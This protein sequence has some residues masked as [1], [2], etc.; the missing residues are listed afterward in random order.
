MHCCVSANRCMRLLP[1]D[2]FSVFGYDPALDI[3]LHGMDVMGK[4]K[5]KNRASKF[6]AAAVVDEA[7]AAFLASSAGAETQE[8][9][10]RRRSESG[11]FEPAPSPAASPLPIRRIRGQQADNPNMDSF[12]TGSTH[13]RSTVAD[14]AKALAPTNARVGGMNMFGEFRAE[15]EGLAAA[16]KERALKED[17]PD[18]ALNSHK[19]S[20]RANSGCANELLMYPLQ[21]RFS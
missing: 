1:T 5:K 6:N 10:G 20:S 3:Q 14:D 15:Q 12:V 11:A 7:V 21:F 9:L 19:A 16:D 17:L 2:P 8:R 13:E 4:R 18:E